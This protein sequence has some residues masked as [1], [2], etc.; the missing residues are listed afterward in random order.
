MEQAHDRGD[1]VRSAPGDVAANVTVRIFARNRRAR[2]IRMDINHRDVDALHLF[3][4]IEP[5]Q[6][7]RPSGRDVFEQNVCNNEP[8]S[9]RR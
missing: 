7:P 4:A 3:G 8:A 2:R 6:L 5:A 9:R 1:N